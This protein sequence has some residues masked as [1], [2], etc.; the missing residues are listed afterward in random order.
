MLSEI[1]KEF[2][3]EEVGIELEARLD[4]SCVPFSYIGEI[5]KNTLLSKQTVK[6][7]CGCD[8]DRKQLAAILAL[9]LILTATILSQPIGLATAL[10]P[11]IEW[12]Q[13]YNYNSA[14]ASWMNAMIQTSDGGYALAGGTMVIVFG[15]IG[16]WLVKADPAGF[17]QWEQAAYTELNSNVGSAKALIQT[18]DGGYTLV[19]NNYLVKTDSQGSMQWGQKYNDADIS[20]VIET[21]ENDYGDDGKY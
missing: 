10:A 18:S 14:N 8:L 19:G 3:S 6:L 4:R 9:S 7:S 17:K 21:N 1:Q 12:K 16:F 2:K 5:F 15:V 13:T 11:S 20:S